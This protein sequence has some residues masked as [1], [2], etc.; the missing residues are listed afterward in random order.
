MLLLKQLSAP[1]DGKVASAALSLESGLGDAPGSAA[2]LRAA[3]DSPDEL[4]AGFTKLDKVPMLKV[5]EAV[6]SGCSCSCSSL[7]VQMT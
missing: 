4:P 1:T 6:W 7:I 2:A 5:R 3:L